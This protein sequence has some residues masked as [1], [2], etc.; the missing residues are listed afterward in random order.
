MVL[1]LISPDSSLLRLIDYSSNA[2]L[3]NPSPT[4][5]T[6][7]VARRLTI[8]VKRPVFGCGMQQGERK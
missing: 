1:L 8:L 3:S 4:A 2:T 6:S 5:P 7:G